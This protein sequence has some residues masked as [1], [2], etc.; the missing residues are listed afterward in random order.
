[1]GYNLIPGNR[2]QIFLMPQSMDDWPPKD[3]L[4]RFVVSAVAV[5]DLKP[6]YRR[7]RS[8]GWGRPP[9]TRR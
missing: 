7:C 9:T 2:N 8:D 5:L 6:F 3:H 1:M 4:A